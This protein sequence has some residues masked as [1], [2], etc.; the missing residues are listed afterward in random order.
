VGIRVV[1]IFLV[2]ATLVSAFFYPLWTGMQTPFAFW[3][4]HI[5]LPTWR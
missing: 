1:V 3:Q 2:V 4:L 5:W